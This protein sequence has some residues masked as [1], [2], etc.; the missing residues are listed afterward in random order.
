MKDKDWRRLLEQMRNGLVVPV[1]GSRLLV[2]AQGV[3]LSAR[4]AQ[5]V[6]DEAELDINPKSLPP[7]RELNELVTRL[8]AQRVA[9]VELQALYGDVDA[10]LR[11][12]EAEGLEVPTPL[13]QLAAITD[14]PLMVT[15]S[16]DGL[17]ARA[18]GDA[19]RGVNEVVH[20]PKLPT[21]EGADLPLDWQEHEGVVQVL[22]LFGKAR[23][24]PLFAI[25][26]EDVLEYAHNII[27]DGSH[28][29][30]AFLGA[31]RDRSLLI[32]GCNFPDWLSRFVL[33]ATRKGRLAD[34]KGG[35]EWLVEGL[36]QEDPFVGFLGNYSPETEALDVDP[37]QFVDEL[38]QRWIAEQKPA[39]ATNGT[40]GV[41]VAA[42]A[43]APLPSPDSKMFFISYSRTTDLA[44]AQAL[45]DALMQQLSVG[46]DE[47]WFDRETLEPGDIYTQ[48]ILDGI[49]SCR[50]FVPLVSRAATGREKAF[51]FREWDEATQ[52]LP[53][54]NRKYL[55]PLVV[56]ADNHPETYQQPSVVAWRERKI[57][58]WHAPSGLPDESALKSL[59][60]LVRDARRPRG[61]G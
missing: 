21:S 43:P 9:P 44:H 17:L 53:E 39:V 49:R 36:G 24:T 23:P 48:R 27:A 19:G 6:I 4:V 50:Y 26:D 41:A 7:F 57:N 16:H 30:T 5:I 25:H 12:L 51:V 37:V 14:F 34:P 18:L 28:A 15:V 55:L 52:Q 46:A 42:V 59:R 1:I 31:L 61:A 45:K 11:R 58:F 54:M 22:Y 20:S 47:I 60:E 13:R 40:A 10:A 8:K 38:Y 35:R 56:D 29:P 32:V 3:P 33:R 2:D